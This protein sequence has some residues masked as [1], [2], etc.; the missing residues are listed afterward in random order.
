VSQG[1]SANNTISNTEVAGAL[2]LLF[3]GS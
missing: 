1:L 3:S 2:V